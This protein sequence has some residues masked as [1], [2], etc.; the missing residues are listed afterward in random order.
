MP[1]TGGTLFKTILGKVKTDGWGSFLARPSLIGLL[2][3]A[4]VLHTHKSEVSVTEKLCIWEAPSSNFGHVTGNPD[5][6]LLLGFPQAL[7][8]NARIVPW[9]GHKV[10]MAVTKNSTTF[11]CVTPCSLWAAHLHF[12]ETQC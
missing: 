5:S 4:Q 10:F 11:W 3:T 12:G 9:L 6:T 7:Q 8:Q 2:H 1:S